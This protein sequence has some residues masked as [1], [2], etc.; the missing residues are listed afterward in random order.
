MPSATTEKVVRPPPRE[1]VEQAEHRVEPEEPARPAVDARHRHMGQ[2]PEDDQDPEDEEDPAPDVG[3][4]E[5][6]Q[7]WPRTRAR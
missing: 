2:Q 4:A 5:G 6:V 1:Q 3:R 7:Q